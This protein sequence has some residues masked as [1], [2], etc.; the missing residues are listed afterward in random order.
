[1]CFIDL[2]TFVSILTH[3]LLNKRYVWYFIPRVLE[4]FGGGWYREGIGTI[5][6][7][8]QT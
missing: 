5:Q 6:V 2:N 1:M 3:L 8:Q 4:C 7:C